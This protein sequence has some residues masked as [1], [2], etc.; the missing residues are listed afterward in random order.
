MSTRLV[1]GLLSV[2]AAYLLAAYCF[3]ELG[4]GA[5]IHHSGQWSIAFLLLALAVSPLRRFTPSANWFRVITQ[6]RR[7]I[8]VA[9]FAYALLHTL[10]Y[11]EYK[12]GAGLILT[13]ALR[14][15]LAT[16]WLAMLVMLALA[17]T[18]NDYSVQRLGRSWKTLHR[19][20]YP[21]AALSFLHWFL[22]SINLWPATLCLIL[23]LVL[24]LARRF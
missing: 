4:Y 12:W 14:P 1:W 15:G 20:V 7:A 9:S 24:L 18:S 21:A 10:V 2:P 23:L 19:L 5:F 8:G 11:L 16:A 3:A 6:Q 17:L 22:S 13:E